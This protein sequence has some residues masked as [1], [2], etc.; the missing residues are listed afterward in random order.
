[1]IAGAGAGFLLDYC[2]AVVQ[3]ERGASACF[4]LGIRLAAVGRQ[5]TVVHIETC[6]IA[7]FAHRPLLLVVGN[8]RRNPAHNKNQNRKVGKSRAGEEH[9]G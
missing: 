3:V 8:A 6:T 9:P 1:M 2:E 7:K 5:G 4:R